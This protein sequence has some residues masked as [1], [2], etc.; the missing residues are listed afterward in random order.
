[1]KKIS[2][3]RGA[4]LRS[5]VFLKSLNQPK[6]FRTLSKDLTNIHQYLLNFSRDDEEMRIFCSFKLI[7]K[8]AKSNL[9]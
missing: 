7:I 9:E 6:I 8:A 3:K 4:P 2:A 5:S 1:M